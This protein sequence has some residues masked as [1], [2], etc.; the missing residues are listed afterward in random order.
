MLNTYS[1]IAV[2]D[3]AP[4]VDADGNAVSDVALN[5]AG[6]DALYQWLVY[7][8]LPLPDSD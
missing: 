8:L 4:F 1:V 7:S 5:T 6:A 2:N 3:A